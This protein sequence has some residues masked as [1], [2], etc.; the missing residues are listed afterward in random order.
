MA[1]ETLAATAM[2]V[3]AIFILPRYLISGLTTVTQFLEKR[4]DVTLNTLTSILFLT[5][6]VVVLL[7]T[8][9]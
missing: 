3:K 7:P 4:F 9:L 5:G 8:I 1:G 6:Y 2:V